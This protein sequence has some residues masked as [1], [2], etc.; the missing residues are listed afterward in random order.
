MTAALFS[1]LPRSKAQLTRFVL[2]WVLMALS[3]PAL[4]GSRTLSKYLVRATW[5]DVPHLSEDAKKQQLASYPPHM[6]DAKSKGIPMLGA[7]AIYPVPETEITVAD[8]PIP[9]H[10]R[11]VYGMDV[12][13][14]FTAACWLAQNPDTGAIYVYSVYKQSQM[15]PSVHAN[16]IKGRGEWIP[17]VIDPASAGA[18]QFDGRR[19][20]DMYQ[21]L[22]LSLAAADNSVESGLY[23][24]W[25]ALSTGQ[26]KVF[27]SCIPWFAEYR[28]Y[29][30]DEKGKIIKKDDHIMDAFRYALVSGLSRAKCK[31]VQEQAVARPQS[32]RGAGG[33]MG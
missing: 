13:W 26:C 30:R 15:E 14:N 2:F 31:P 32:Y 5:D 7:G 23:K 33:W 1:L 27:A 18:S 19:L 11:K 10:W 6:R 9:P 8:F 17:G 22:G 28:N 24:C 21:K 25:E 20:L 16:G 29:H 12:G 3:I 4:F